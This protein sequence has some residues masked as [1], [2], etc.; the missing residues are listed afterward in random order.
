MDALIKEFRAAYAGQHGNDLART[1][2]P[3]MQLNAARLMAVWESGNV[4]SIKDD[5]RFLFV[6]DK[7]GR[8]HMSPDEAEGWQEIYYSYWKALGEI[9]AAEGLRKSRVK[10]RL[11]RLRRLLSSDATV[12]EPGIARSPLHAGC[13][14]L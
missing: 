6:R 5:L 8:L 1:L 7:S 3:D 12:A 2:T 9:L 10:V 14:T 4:Q 11:L 13:R